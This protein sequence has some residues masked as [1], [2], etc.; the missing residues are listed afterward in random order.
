[1]ECAVTTQLPW[2]HATS[3]S[4]P[5]CFLCIKIDLLSGTSWQTL[6]AMDHPLGKAMLLALGICGLGC[7]LGKS[8]DQQ[9]RP[10][11][12]VASEDPAA[13]KQDKPSLAQ[14]KQ[15]EAEARDAHRKA[16]A[17]AK[18]EPP[19]ASEP[20]A[21]PT[22]SAAEE[23]QTATTPTAAAASGASGQ[24]PEAKTAG[25]G[26]AGTAPVAPSATAPAASSAPASVPSGLKM[27]SEACL[28]Q[29]SK[30]LQDCLKPQADKPVD[31]KV[32]ASCTQ[33]F[34]SCKTACL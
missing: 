33:A 25:A 30:A 17:A 8:D 2:S 18:T 19:P 1:M 6:V 23:A 27:P 32:T 9:T 16:G 29:C 4:R 10:L 3:I 15:P 24:E 14:P 7:R 26:Q 31:F 34:E 5:C 20:P 21:T 11:P 12:E 13:P 28:T 22:A